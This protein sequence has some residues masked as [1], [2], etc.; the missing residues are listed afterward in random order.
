MTPTRRLLLVLV[1]LLAGGTARVQAQTS[2]SASHRVFVGV[3]PITVMAVSGDPMPM[4]IVLDS[5]SSKSVLDASTFYNATTSVDRVQIEARM[6]EPMPDGLRLRLRAESSLG[7]SLGVVNL[8]GD[9]RSRRVVGNMARGL[10]NGR[11]LEYE[12]VADPGLGPVP[13]QSRMVVLSF[14]NPETGYRQEISQ[15][16]RFSVLSSETGSTSLR[17]TT[18]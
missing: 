17:S 15:L 8:T 9:G 4:N 2:A 7:N 18:N 3:E 16:I 5:G 6:D 14:V 11:R 13:F 10:E 1:L 12:L